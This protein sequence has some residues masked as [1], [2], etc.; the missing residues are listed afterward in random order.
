MTTARLTLPHFYEP[1]DGFFWFE[2]CYKRLIATL[3]TTRRGEFVEIGSYKGKSLAFAAI[4]AIN[5][6]IDVRFHAVDSWQDGF[7]QKGEDIRAEFDRNTATIS[8]L[9]RVWPMDSSKAAEFFEP[10]SVDVVF[11]DGDHSYEACKRDIL[12]WWPKL[13]HGGF[14][15]GDDF[16]MQPV[17]QAVTEQF[18]PRYILI[19]GHA[20]T[21]EPLVWP[22]WFVRK[23]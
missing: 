12:T 3:P 8:D 16:M 7:A 2:E 13:R 9:I 5:R 11:V 4:E 18:A 22:S 1:L 17:C 10:E 14:M 21:P 20:T 19:H 23:E 15:A 6:G